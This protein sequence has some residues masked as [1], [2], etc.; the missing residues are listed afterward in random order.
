MIQQITALL[1]KPEDLL[2]A[3]VHASVHLYS[4]SP[5]TSYIYTHEYI[6]CNSYYIKHTYLKTKEN[7]QNKA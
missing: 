6:L 3:L 4:P 7:S 1:T 2:W 5:Q